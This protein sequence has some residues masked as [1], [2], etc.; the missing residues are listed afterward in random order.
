V[1]AQQPVLRMADFD[2]KFIL[3][4]DVSGIGVATVLLH[5]EHQGA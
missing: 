5:Q 1:T 2:R 4:T 3:Q